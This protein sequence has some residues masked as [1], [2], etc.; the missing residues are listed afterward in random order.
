MR[1]RSPVLSRV[2][3]SALVLGPLLGAST[4]THAKPPEPAA[5]C[6]QRG[7][8]TFDKDTT[9]SDASGR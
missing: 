9:L 2:L 7:K 6:G 1:S 8:V 5:Q 3:A 4:S